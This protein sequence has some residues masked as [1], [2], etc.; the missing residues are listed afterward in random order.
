MKNPPHLFQPTDLYEKSVDADAA[1]PSI[2]NQL[3]KRWLAGGPMLC[4][5]S[6][7][8]NSLRMC[9]M[10]GCGRKN[11]ESGRHRWRPRQ[12]DIQAI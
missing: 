8:E 2:V 1:G 4:V 10:V 7:F 5:K 12:S 9:F 3:V 6:L 11:T